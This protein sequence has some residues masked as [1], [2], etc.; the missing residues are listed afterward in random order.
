MT[1]YLKYVVVQDGGL[2]LPIIFPAVLD[3]NKVCPGLKVIA[4]GEVS[5]SPDGLTALR[6]SPWG[7]SVTLGVKCRVIEDREL[8]TRELNRPLRD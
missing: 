3:H 2:E 5:I 7:Q 6:C 8:I 4:A 1:D